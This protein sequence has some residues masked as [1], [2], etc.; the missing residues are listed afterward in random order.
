MKP[1]Q[2]AIAI[3]NP[4][5]LDDTVTVGVI[6]GMA[7][8]PEL[9]KTLGLSVNQG[10][11]VIS[12]TQDSP[13]A[14]AGLKAGNLDTTGAP[15][16][17]GDVITAIDGK[18]VA[19][20]QEISTYINTK[21]VGDT[22]TLSVLRNGANTDVQVTLGTWPTNLTPGTTPRPSPQPAPLPQPQPQPRPRMPGR[23][24]YRQS[25]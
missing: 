6:S 24:Y 20:V 2:L 23:G 16:T 1:G 7:V 22:V 21:S 17:G 25:N 8:T 4:Y 14:K 18:A 10:V 13:A 11:Y 3:G 5:G 19:S 15:A 12:V 9:A